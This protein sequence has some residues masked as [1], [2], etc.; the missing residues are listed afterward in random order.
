MQPLA[1]KRDSSATSKTLPQH[2][3]FGRLR[4]TVAS[5]W[6]AAAVHAGWTVIVGSSSMPIH[7]AQSRHMLSGI[8][9]VGAT[10]S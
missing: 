4:F 8:Y 7:R 5:A 2:G 10:P 6:E 9:G 1:L 3:Q